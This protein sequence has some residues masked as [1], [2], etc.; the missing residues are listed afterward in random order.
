M[1]VRRRVGYHSLDAFESS[2]PDRIE[3]ARRRT[4]DAP[5]RRS[6]SRVCDPLA[7]RELRTNG[8][9]SV[10]LP[11]GQPVGVTSGAPTV[12]P[13]G[14]YTVVLTGPGGCTAMPHFNL[15]GP[16]EAIHDNLNEGESDNFTYNAYFLPNSTYT[17][18]SDAAPCVVHTFRDLRKHRGHGARQ[19]G[20]AG[21]SVEPAHHGRAHR[22]SLPRMSC[23]SAERSPARSARPESSRS[24]SRARASPA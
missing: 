20:P 3:R 11:N 6:G 2:A 24:R 18:S 4:A 1:H 21:S 13:A 8:A 17:W 5:G 7:Q 22:T 16:G 14:F 12:I 10:A 23:R 19:H 15:N 9:I